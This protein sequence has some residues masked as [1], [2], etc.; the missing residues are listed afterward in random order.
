MP[1]DELVDGADEHHLGGQW[2]VRRG[3]PDM[4]PDPARLHDPA[5]RGVDVRQLLG[6]ELED[7][8]PALAGFEVDPP[9][10]AQLEHRAG[11]GRLLV[12]DVE[13]DD[14][15]RGPGPGVGDVGP[16]REGVARRLEDAPVE[17]EVVDREAAVRISSGDP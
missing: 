16:D 15:V 1:L 5:V 7:D 6:R 13:L 12:A 14:L 4:D 8:G 17:P 9:E 10:A 2:Q 3:P 11:D